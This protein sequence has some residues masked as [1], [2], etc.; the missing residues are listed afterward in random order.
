MDR[1][2]SHCDRTAAASEARNEMTSAG[3]S[4]DGACGLIQPL[5][6]TAR[7]RPTNEIE[8]IYPNDQFNEIP[9]NL[10]LDREQGMIDVE[11]LPTWPTKEPLAT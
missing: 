5:T 9:H 1:V 4:A 3:I 10:F 2:C 7:L 6:R 11:D 8:D